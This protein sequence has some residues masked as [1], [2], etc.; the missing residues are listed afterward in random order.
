MDKEL[1][2]LL[3]GGK[4]EG[5]TP[6]RSRAMRA[7]RGKGNKSTESRLRLAL[8]RAG[9]RGWTMHPRTVKGK[10][11][12]YFPAHR[13]AVFVDG[14]FWH[15]CGDCGHI[16]KTNTGFWRAKIAKNRDRDSR[17]TACLREQGIVV[18]R[19]WEHELDA[20]LEVCL[21]KIQARL[22]AQTD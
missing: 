21:D 13:L 15:G 19:F 16:P 4:F 14:C 12:F 1:R 8:V 6:E 17:T 10:P 3:K 5:V 11:D 22:V 18:L 7:V 2:K 20:D 9:V